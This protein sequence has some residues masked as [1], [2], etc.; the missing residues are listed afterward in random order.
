[1]PRDS[2]EVGCGYHWLPFLLK[3]DSFVCQFSR[4]N[5]RCS[6]GSRIRISESPSVCRVCGESPPLRQIS[7]RERMN[8]SAG[9]NAGVLRSAQDFAC[10]L[11]RRQS[12]S[13]YRKSGLPSNRPLSCSEYNPFTVFRYD[14]FMPRRLVC[15]NPKTTPRGF[16]ALAAL[17]FD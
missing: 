3:S 1:M 4:Q 15:H 7:R 11:G 13:R 16:R 8:T 14:S 17:R 10:G 9:S 5:D 6:T 12:G 2:R